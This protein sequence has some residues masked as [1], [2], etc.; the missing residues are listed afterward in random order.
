M[1]HTVALDG[2]SCPQMDGNTYIQ[3]RG[4]ALGRYG[5]NKTSEP[6]DLIFDENAEKAV[7]E[8]LGDR[9]ASVYYC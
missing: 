5:E 4:G 8:I 7:K 6:D 9:E 1:I 2:A 3:H